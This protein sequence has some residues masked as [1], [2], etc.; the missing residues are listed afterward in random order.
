MSP[1]V[2]LA[3]GYASFLLAVAVGLDRLARHAHHRCERYRTAGFRYHL[4]HDG[5]ICPQDQWLWPAEFDHHRRLVRYRAKPSVCNACPVKTQCTTSPHGREIVRAIDPWPHSEAGRFHRGLALMLTG[6][7]ELI[8][9]IEMTRHHT[10]VT[11]AALAAPMALAGGLG[12]RFLDHLRHTPTGFPDPTPSTGLRLTAA[13]R[14][15]DQSADHTAPTSEGASRTRWH[16]HPSP[17]RAAQTD[18]VPASRTR[19]GSDPP[20]PPPSRPNA[21]RRNR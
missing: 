5:W 2:V 3:A 15:A 20:M 7:A 16:A 10:P 18:G 8:L 11:L 12:W 14:P 17:Q 13:D 21:G 9:L 6:L 1:E 19:W 4:P